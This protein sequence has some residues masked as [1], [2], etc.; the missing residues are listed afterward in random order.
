M[1]VLFEALEQLP[2][3]E[4]QSIREKAQKVVTDQLVADGYGRLEASQSARRVVIALG[5]ENIIAIKN[6]GI[7]EVDGVLTDTGSG[8]PDY[9]VPVGRITPINADSIDDNG[10][11]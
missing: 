8:K 6:L 1:S 11:V 7:Y 10:T 2:D 5:A 9:Q 3:Q 4:V